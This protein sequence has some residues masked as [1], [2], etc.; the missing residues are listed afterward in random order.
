MSI[1][2]KQGICVCVCVC[3]TRYHRGAVWKGLEFH[4]QR[5]CGRMTKCCMCGR[6]SGKYILHER[7]WQW[8]LSGRFVGA[9][10]VSKCC[11]C[12]AAVVG[13]WCMHGRMMAPTAVTNM[14][15]LCFFPKS[16]NMFFCHHMLQKECQQDITGVR[17]RH[18]LWYQKWWICWFGSHPRGADK[19]TTLVGSWHNKIFWMMSEGK[20]MSAVHPDTKL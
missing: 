7:T 19:W 2:S 6:T 3:V 5:L 18:W 17:S 15:S 10:V 8:W 14:W 20:V 1:A 9:R 4:E 11:I 16:W 12:E 13:E